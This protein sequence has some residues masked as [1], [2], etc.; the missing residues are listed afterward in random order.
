M[1]VMQETKPCPQCRVPIQK[2]E[3]CDQMW[4]TRCHTA[5]DWSSLRVLPSSQIHNPHLVSFQSQVDLMESRN[6]VLPAV[7]SE[8]ALHIYFQQRPLLATVASVVKDAVM[9]AFKEAE[10]IRRTKL[11]LLQRSLFQ[12]PL[13]ANMEARVEFIEGRAT[14]SDFVQH[15]VR[16]ENSLTKR[17]EAF[18]SLQERVAFT[19]KVLQN[20]FLCHHPEDVQRMVLEPLSSNQRKNSSFG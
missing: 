20:L 2:S 6:P 10:T 9:C 13:L 5:F 15:L 16:R 17:W 12:E 4:C 19:D 18:R 14:E 3:G 7:L 11:P 1:V 8:H